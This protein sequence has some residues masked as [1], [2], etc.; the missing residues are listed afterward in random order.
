VVGGY[1]FPEFMAKI[2]ENTIL[3]K[4][5]H[6]IFELP[7]VLDQAITITRAPVAIQNAIIALSQRCR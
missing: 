4:V 6:R 2:L 5:N 7:I 3:E 1:V